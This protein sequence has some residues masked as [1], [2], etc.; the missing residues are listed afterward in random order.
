M[1]NKFYFFTDV[2]LLNLQVIDDAFGPVNGF[3]A[4]KFQLCNKHTATG[5]PTAYSICSGTVFFQQNTEDSALLNMV[6]KPYEQLGKGMPNIDY[7]IYRGIKKDSIIDV[8]G[9]EIVASGTNDLSTSIWDSQNKRNESIDKAQ[10]NPTGTTSESPPMELLGV[11]YTPMALAPYTLDDT[12]PISEVFFS[13]DIEYQLPTVKGGWSLGEFDSAN[14][15][16][17]I[18]F[19]NIRKDLNAGEIRGNKVVLEVAELTGGEDQSAVF[20]HWNLK[21]QILTYLDAAAFFG[22]FYDGGLLA[23]KSIDAD[24]TNY[25]GDNLYLEVL[26]KYYNKNTVYLDVRNEF[27]HSFNFNK[28]YVDELLIAFDD[29]SSLASINYYRDFWPLLMVKTDFPSGNTT[30]RNF[31]RI[32]FPKGD[33]DFPRLFINKGTNEGSFPHNVSFDNQFYNL[34][35]DSGSTY[36][37]NEIKILTPNFVGGDTAPISNYLRLSYLKSLPGLGHRLTAGTVPQK[38]IGIDYLFRLVNL[39]TK[40]KEDATKTQIQ[41]YENL[42]YVDMRVFNKHSFLAKQGVAKTPVGD[43]IYFAFSSQTLETDRENPSGIIMESRESNESAMFRILSENSGGL[44]STST[45]EVD[46]SP[47]VLEQMSIFYDGEEDSSVRI[48]NPNELV[49]VR[50]TSDDMIEINDIISDPVN[51]FIEDFPIMLG[52]KIGEAGFDDNYRFSYNRFDFSV[53]GYYLNTGTNEIE[54]K[55]VD[56]GIRSYRLQKNLK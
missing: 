32:I 8:A 55:E 44:F 49:Y 25:S 22:G 30:D 2:D 41:I 27:N 54:I 21:E 31:L 12:D 15:G 17:D 42:F 3:E 50:F 35:N 46:G 36:N 26:E 47:I 9:V 52:I 37:L 24:F 23:K 13:T 5:S 53:D 33:N 48:L 7:F 10:D 40:W 6:L 28:N 29:V 20:T 4:S 16:L 1:A 39:K 43:T 56:T 34:I 51:G 19:S 45:I 14:F 11:N 38:T 18:V